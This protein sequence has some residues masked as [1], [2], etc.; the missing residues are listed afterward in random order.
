MWGLQ[1]KVRGMSRRESARQ[2]VITAAK[3]IRI[4]L[5]IIKD[6]PLS[7]LFF[8]PRFTLAVHTWPHVL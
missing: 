2:P 1:S 7:G 5:F 4:L 8:K 6:L 3:Q